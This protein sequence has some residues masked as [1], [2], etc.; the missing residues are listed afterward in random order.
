M[1]EYVEKTL[2]PVTLLLII[3]RERFFHFGERFHDSLLIIPFNGISQ[4]RLKGF[5]G[6]GVKA[7]P[8]LRRFERFPRLP[9]GYCRLPGEFGDFRVV[10][11]LGCIHPGGRMS[12]RHAGHGVRCS[13]GGGKNCGGE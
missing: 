2:N 13:H 1:A 5:F 7:Q 4:Y 11:F 9:A 10:L 3:R 6:F 12:C 8:E